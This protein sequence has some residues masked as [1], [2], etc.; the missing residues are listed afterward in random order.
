MS[1]HYL[2]KFKCKSRGSLIFV[3]Y[4][5]IIQLLALLEDLNRGATE[6]VVY[7]PQQT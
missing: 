4:V 7:H 5:L 3:A 6:V 1:Y 2:L